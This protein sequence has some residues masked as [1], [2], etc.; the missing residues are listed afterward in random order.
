MKGD[1]FRCLSKALETSRYFC[2]ILV[3]R[4]LCM[5]RYDFIISKCYQ[6]KAKL[7]YEDIF[8]SY[9]LVA[10]VCLCRELVS[11]NFNKYF[12]YKI[13]GFVTVVH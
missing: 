9:T 1:P 13:H 10:N 7:I 3:T 5:Q 8:N 6:F 11:S 12:R 4:A 2:V